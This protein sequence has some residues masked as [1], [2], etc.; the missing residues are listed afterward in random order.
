MVRRVNLWHGLDETPEDAGTS[1]YKRKTKANGYDVN[2]LRRNIDF[3]G[4]W[5]L[6]DWAHFIAI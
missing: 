2:Q 1:I 3:P 4:W 5:G 6:S